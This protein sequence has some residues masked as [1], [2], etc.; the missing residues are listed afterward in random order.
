[1]LHHTYPH[2]C[3]I[4]L[5]H[6][7]AASH[8]PTRVMHHTYPHACCITLTHTCAASHL[9]TRVLHHTHPHACCITLTHTSAASH[10]PTRVLH[11]TYPHACL[12]YTTLPTRVLH[13]T[14][15]HKAVSHPH[16]CC[17]TL[18]YTSAVSLFE[19]V[20]NGAVDVS[21]LGSLRNL[22]VRGICFQW[23]WYKSLYATQWIIFKQC[24][25]QIVS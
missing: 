4:T 22:F 19:I 23:V 13:R 12:W 7:S 2:E 6:T 8:L 24:D 10:L 16:E 9:P 3:C 18:T 17:I 15:P 21:D 20:D 11:H 14:Y 5:T 25:V 1:M